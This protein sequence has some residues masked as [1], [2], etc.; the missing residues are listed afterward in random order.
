MADTRDPILA[1]DT[2]PT[3]WTALESWARSLSPW[4]QYIIAVAIS[5][6][7]LSDEESDEAYNRFLRING[8]AAVGEDDEDQLPPLTGRP[9]TTLEGKLVL[10][11]IDGLAG[12]NALPE[13]ATI[14]FGSGLTVIY[15]RNGAGKSGFVRLI[16]NACFSRQKPPIVG[17]IYADGERPVPTAQFHISI[18]DTIQNPITFAPAAAASELQR[19]SVFDAAVARHHLTQ[20]FPFEFK[21]A[22][23]DV[24][25]ELVRVYGRIAEKLD[26]EIARR[27]VANEF[28]QSFLGGGTEVHTAIAG[29]GPNTDLGPLREL[30]SYGESESARIT[31]LEKQILALRTQSPKEVLAALREAA[32]DIQALRSQLLQLCGYFTETA[33]TEHRTLISR[34]KDALAIATAAGSDQ[35]KRPFFNAVGTPEWERFATNM[36]AL[37]RREHKAYPAS[38]DRCLLCERVF[39]E[40]SRTHVAALLAFVESDYRTTAAEAHATAQASAQALSALD[41]NVFSSS[42]RVR[43]HVRKLAPDLET[44]IEATRS[45]LASARDSSVTDVAQ[46]TATTSPVDVAGVIAQIDL[47][48]GRIASDIARLQTDNTEVA[49]TSLELE[50]RTLR[51]RQ[52]LSQLLPAIETYVIDAEWAQRARTAKNSLSTRPIT[53]K[54]KELFVQVVGDTY[55]KNLVAECGRL[56]CDVPVEMQTMGRSGQTLRALA[57]KGGHKPEGILSEGEQ[58]AV[59]L[60]DFLTEVGLNPASAGIVFDDPV[61]SQD[62]QRKERI[63]LRLVDEAQHRQ[64]IVFTHDLVFLNQLLVAAD[65][66]RCDLKCHWIDRSAD[67]QPGQVA[68]GDSPVTSWAYENTSRAEHALSIAKLTMG[69]DREDAVR[70][71]MG[72]LRT[73]LEETVVRKIFKDAV[74]RWS[75]QVRVTT[76]RRI[77]WDNRKIEEVCALYEDLSRFIE[78][79]SHTDEATGAPAT[80]GDL[81]ARIVQVKELLRWARADRPKNV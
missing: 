21:P 69:T 65:A 22:G 51:H 6:G 59:A 17:N 33:V 39:D 29:L 36:H 23:F 77:N 25:P 45:S 19:I 68:I 53:E 37:A 8:L 40:V 71:G 62:H 72:A 73:T 38:D 63:A 50:R 34:A 76:L 57:M 12:I 66:N 64:V 9:N 60:A 26:G 24:F 35:F 10:T 3:I 41:F 46:L 5:R 80:V 31:E 18:G 47:L 78:A 2:T 28:P 14:T 7:R 30:A 11:A 67:G 20:A 61:T 48:M 52:V 75:D 54:E 55:R 74:P 16:A 70:K 42:S 49:I 58:K 79:H 81:E 4:Q 32:D 27:A 56:G 44:I 15:G 43:S 13:G 1:T